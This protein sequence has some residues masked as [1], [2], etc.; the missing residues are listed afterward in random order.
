MIDPG[1][2]GSDSGA[3]GYGLR[4][5]DVTL[6]ISQKVNENLTGNY[7]VETKMTRNSDVYIPLKQ[8]TDLANQWGADLFLSIHNNAGGGTGYEDYVYIKP[9]A[10]DK[11]VQDEIHHE[12]SKVLAEYKKKNRGKKAANF[13]VLRE[14]KMASVL[15]EILFIDNQADAALL[16][17][18]MFL[19]DIAEAIST[20][21][22]NALELPE[23]GNGNGVSSIPAQPKNPAPPKENIPVSKAKIPVSKA[24]GTYIVTASTLHVR[25]GNGSQFP[26]LGYL[27]KNNVVNVT[28]KAPNNW[29]Q[30]TFKGK[31]G[32]VSGAYLKKKTAQKPQTKPKNAIKVNK[33]SGTYKVTAS[34]L[35]VRSGNG[36]NYKSI[37]YLK[38]NAVI[39]VTGKTANGWYRINHKGKT[40]YVSG[41]YLKAHKT[42]GKP[43]TSGKKVSGAS[44]TYKVTASTLFVRS[45]N[46]TSFKTIGSLSRGA[47]VNVTGKTANGWY[48][49]QYKGKTGYASGKYLKR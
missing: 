8:R 33:A 20:G 29:Y 30:V 19:T 27:K 11:K 17:N 24:S 38:K 48:R 41:K 2:G 26:S 49:I 39:K 22:A 36:T 35:Y 40:G 28:G 45:G 16:K 37:G 46:G 18:D 10:E 13:H 5:K 4:E 21:V 32:Y 1:H 23:K 9:T 6:K 7:V 12:I 31:K 15:L 14:S 34:K 42:A 3:T 25:S 44:G 47:K 43:K